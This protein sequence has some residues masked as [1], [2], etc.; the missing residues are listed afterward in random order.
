MN[1]IEGLYCLIMIEKE[2]FSYKNLTEKYL[3]ILPEEHM[4]LISRS[5][6]HF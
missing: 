1:N 5:C 3:K 6:Q 4:K 2:F